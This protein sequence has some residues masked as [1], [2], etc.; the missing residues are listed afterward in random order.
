MS[1]KQNIVRSKN[2]ADINSPGKHHKNT[3]PTI[4]ILSVAFALLLTCIGLFAW[5]I[6]KMRIYEFDYI[7]M[8][9]RVVDIKSHVSGD[10]HDTYYYYVI[11]YEF[12]GQEYSFT[13][14]VGRNYSDGFSDIGKYTEIYVNP[15]RPDQAVRVISSGSVSIGYS[16]CY[17]IF[18]FCYAIGM[19]M[20][21]GIIGNS[22]KKRFMFIWGIEILLGIALFLL[23]WLGIPNSSFGEV[24]ARIDGSIGIIVVC[25]LA[26]LAT[27]VDGAIA[28]EVRSY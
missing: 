16:F 2:A 3:K 5:N 15:Q 27:V 8:P 11:S 25:G 14:D 19:N 7:K 26:L 4:I 18:C 20:L 12:E 10:K 6:V 21:F 23:P 9:G 22:L 24:F 1:K 28:Y 17:C 13:D